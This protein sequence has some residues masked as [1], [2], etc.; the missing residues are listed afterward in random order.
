MINSEALV[1]TPYKILC[2]GALDN[3]FP[4]SIN[5]P[6]ILHSNHQNGRLDLAICEKLPQHLEHRLLP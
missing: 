3:H 2:T 6:V 4:V 1:K 5:V